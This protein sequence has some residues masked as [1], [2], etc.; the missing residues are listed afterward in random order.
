MVLGDVRD[1]VRLDER[2]RA[3]RARP[4]L[5]CGRA[6][7]CADGRAQPARG[8]ADQRHRQPQRRRRLPAGRC[9]HDGADLDRQGGQSVER[10]GR[11]Q[12]SGRKLYARRST[13][14]PAMAQ[15]RASSPSGSATS[16]A[17]PGRWCRCSR[18]RSPRADRS[19]SPTRRDALFHVRARGG[20]AGAAG[21]GPRRGRCNRVRPDLRA[22]DGRAGAGSSTSRGR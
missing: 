7:A 17:R 6:E 16:S 14:A 22:R 2:F 13:S 18:N 5:P 8:R 20:G 21:V 9:R 19:P 11:H 12:A 1:R 15:A 4:R 3:L 10:H